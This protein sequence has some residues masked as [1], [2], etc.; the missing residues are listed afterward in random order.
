MA[1]TTALRSARAASTPA[2]LASLV[3][4]ADAFLFD[5]D[6]VLYHGAEA[7]PGAAAALAALRAAG[8]KVLFVTNSASRCVC[9]CVCARARA[10][11]R[12]CVCVC[13]CVCVRACVRARAHACVYS[14]VRTRARIHKRTH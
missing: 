9:V 1:S 5:C 2:A 12:A 4:S 6:G 10:R 14:F 7:E 11:A 13:V 3:R 8:K